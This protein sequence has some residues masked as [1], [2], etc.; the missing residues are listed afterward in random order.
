[1]S[2][3]LAEL[4]KLEC[5]QRHARLSEDRGPMIANKVL[6]MLEAA[7]RD[8]ARVYEHLPELPPTKAIRWNRGRRRRSPIAWDDLPA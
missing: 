3:P 7:F 4:S 8:A 5:V 6:K 2:R 1:M